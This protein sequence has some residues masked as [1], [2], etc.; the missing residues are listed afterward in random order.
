M[1]Q[2]DNLREQLR[3]A[4]DIQASAS[5]T[6]RDLQLQLDCVRSIV[7]DALELS[8]L[9]IELADYNSPENRFQRELDAIQHVVQAHRKHFGEP[10]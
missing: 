10:T 6:P 8:H 2:A 5:A 9:V 4:V 1:D 3:L 7:D